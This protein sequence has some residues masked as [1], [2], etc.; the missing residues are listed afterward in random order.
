MNGAALADV[1]K[2][3]GVLGVFNVGKKD[4][5]LTGEVLMRDD[6]NAAGR[7]RVRD[8]DGLI[9][10]QQVAE[11]N[12]GATPEARKL[13]EDMELLAG[14]DKKNYAA[15]PDAEKQALWE[16]H[17]RIE[18]DALTK[19][20]ASAKSTGARVAA[21]ENR[22]ELEKDLAN[23]S[24]DLSKP[25]YLMAKDSKAAQARK[26]IVDGFRD[27]PA[28][29]DLEAAA[30]KAGVSDFARAMV[31]S[32]ETEFGKLDA[33]QRAAVL[34]AIKGKSDPW[35]QKNL[36]GII[37]QAKTGELLGNVANAPEYVS[38]LSK[39]KGIP[40]SEI[41]AFYAQEKNRGIDY[42]KLVSDAV[43]KYGLT[44]DE[45]HAVYGYTGK[46]FYRELN[47]TLAA[48]GSPEANALA[49]L[50]KSG[51]DKLPNSGPKQYRGYRLNDTAAIAQ[52]D[53]K[54]R[55][56]ETVT[57]EFWSASPNVGD[58]YVGPRNVVI[59]TDKAKDISE[60]AFG[61]NFHE[62]VGKPKYSAE[63]VIP[64]GVRFRI[65][66]IDENG[67]IVLEQE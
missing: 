6:L 50:I 54:F 47:H 15:L 9:H 67:R 20:E 25:P 23:K 26:Q 29:A 16:A 24:F 43:S 34:D 39:F 10:A 52:F 33:T 27:K 36:G 21:A 4:G 30:D 19:E 45:A 7:Q 49:K 55:E 65:T 44:P 53:H 56:G 17:H 3:D 22:A 37:K 18:I 31:R 1:T 28:N 48:G 41:K 63:A 60:L 40:E 42:P 11:A 2:E 8:H 61:V 58:A 62:L 35:I 32:R 38:L 64:P 13:R 5:K 51:I 57:S 12:A 14:L 66:R 46:L 59:Y